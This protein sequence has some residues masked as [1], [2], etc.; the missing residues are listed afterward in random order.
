MMRN[1]A[2][3]LVLCRGARDAEALWWQVER[4]CGLVAPAVV[5]IVQGKDGRRGMLTRRFTLSEMDMPT[6]RGLVDAI[7]ELLQDNARQDR[8]AARRAREARP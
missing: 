3:P 5:L 4:P 7:A 8:L 2:R 6:V 1:P